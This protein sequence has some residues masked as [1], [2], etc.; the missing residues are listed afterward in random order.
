MAKLKITQEQY[1]R[2]LV[3]EQMNRLKSIT[4]GDKSNDKLS[5]EMSNLVFILAKLLGKELS[6]QNKIYLETAIKNKNYF[7]KLKDMLEDSSKTKE[8]ISALELKGMPN[9]TEKLGNKAKEIVDGFNE[10]SGEIKLDD[11]ALHNLLSLVHT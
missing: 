10:L 1:N 7:K 2:I 6:G 11:K 9:P 8:L 4:E 5:N 3:T